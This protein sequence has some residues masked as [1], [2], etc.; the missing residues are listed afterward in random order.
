MLDPNAPLTV[1]QHLTHSTPSDG[2]DIKLITKPIIDG[3][4]LESMNSCI[5]YTYISN[6]RGKQENSWILYS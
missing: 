2:G 6:K 4:E 3:R 5:K 1:L